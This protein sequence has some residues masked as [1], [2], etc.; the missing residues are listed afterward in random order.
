VRYAFIEQQRGSYPLGMLCQVLE[1]SRSGH[2]DWIARGKSSPTTED[3]RLTAKIR[4]V[5]AQSRGTYGSPRVT[6]ALK[7]QGE[8]VNEKR[9]A[10]IMRER[11]IAGRAR[12]KYRATTDSAHS[13]PVAENLLDRQFSPTAPNRAWV[14]DITAIATREG[15][16]YLAVIIDLCTRQ[17]VGFAQAAHLRAELVKEAFLMAYWRHKPARGLLFHSDR[18]SQ[19]A[20]HAFRRLLVGLGMV[21]SMSRKGNCWDNAVAE[22]FFHSLKVEA[23][24]GRTYDT[25]REAQAAISEYILGFFNPLRLHSALGYRTPN[26]YARRLLKVA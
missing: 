1:V 9:V 13:L 12:R 21:Q 4:V 23:V 26:D 19:Y 6:Q 7:A 10:R 8:S 20:A 3:E 2:A 11:A 25:R 16:W 17:V 24:Q 22:S 14:S 15:W 18:G 5:H